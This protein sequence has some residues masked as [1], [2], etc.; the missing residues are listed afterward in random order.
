MKTELVKIEDVPKSGQDKV[1][2]EWAKQKVTMKIINM[3]TKANLM[4][5]AE[6]N[7]FHG[8]TRVGD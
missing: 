4:K 6:S 2:N 7:R 1:L 8:K 3:T 5:M